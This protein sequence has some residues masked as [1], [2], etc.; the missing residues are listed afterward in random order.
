MRTLRQARWLA[1]GVALTMGFNPIYYALSNTFMTDV[2]FV[3]IM[4]LA[5]FFFVRYLRNSSDADLLIGT[6]CSLAATLTRQLA[7]SVPVAFAFSLILRYGAARRNLVRAVAPPAIC[8]VGLLAFQRWLAATGRLGAAYSVP[9]E[10][11]V[12]ALTDVRMIIPTLASRTYISLMYLGWFLLPLLIFAAVPLWRSHGRRATAIF[13]LSIGSI[14]ALGAA[15]ALVGKHVLMPLSSNIVLSSGIGPLTLRDTY[16]LKLNHVP[17]LSHG[18]WPM[19][20][21][22][23]LLGAAVLTT[24]IVFALIDLVRK[25]RPARLNENEAASAFFLLSAAIYLAPLFIAGF[26]DRYL[27]FVMPLLAGSIVSASPGP[28]PSTSRVC[29]LAAVVLLVSLAYFGVCGTRDYLAWNRLRWQAL[30]ELMESK[31]ATAEDI[32]GGFE[33]N[34]LYLYD[35]RYERDASKSWWWVRRDLYRIGF[36]P[37]PGYTIIREYDYSRWLPHGPGKVVVLEK[38]PS[39]SPG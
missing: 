7:V 2:P 4:I 3:A 26:F 17:A 29:R 35:A 10:N 19:V 30:H 36:G 25:L 8:I 32:D 24:A 23:A 13:V 5:S 9:N 18:F 6:A 33:F 20:S 15:R 14:A 16:V 28:L 11:L 34:G 31:H 37:M 39:R 22:A 21:A 27:I 38:S 1:C 12:N